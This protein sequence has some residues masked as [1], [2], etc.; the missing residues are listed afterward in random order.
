MRTFA[1]FID[2]PYG[3]TLYQLKDGRFQIVQAGTLQDLMAGFGYFLASAAFLEVLRT[4]V[5]DLRSASVILFDPAKNEEITGFHEFF[6]DRTLDLE[7]IEAARDSADSLWRY[8]EYLFVSEDL[9]RRLLA[10]F[11]TLEA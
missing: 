2:P 9:C 1:F 3:P 7:S 10:R 8:Y 4:V 5:P 6:V 11:P